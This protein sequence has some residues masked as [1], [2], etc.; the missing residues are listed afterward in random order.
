MF[1][2]F[3]F[4]NLLVTCIIGINPEERLAEQVLLIN[5]QAEEDF[6]AVADTDDLSHAVDYAVVA[7]FCSELAREGKYQMLETLAYDL[8][9]QLKKHFKFNWVKVMI[10]KPSAIPAAE[11]AFVELESGK[12]KRK[13]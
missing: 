5:L 8:N 6:K 1:G 12:R 7:N 11:Y 2:V 10:K 9:F 13:Q 3:G 4:E